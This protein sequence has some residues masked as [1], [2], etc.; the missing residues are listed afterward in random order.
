VVA[1]VIGPTSDAWDDEVATLGSSRSIS[2]AMSI[3][4]CVPHRAADGEVRVRHEIDCDRPDRLIRSPG[5]SR[6]RSESVPKL[7]GALHHPFDNDNREA[8]V[9]RSLA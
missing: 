2:E 8:C 9:S 6:R 4:C 5:P 1:V 3:K 7:R